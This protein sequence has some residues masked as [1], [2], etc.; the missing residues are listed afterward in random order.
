MKKTIMALL[1]V[2]LFFGATNYTASAENLTDYYTD[3]TEKDLKNS[4]ILSPDSKKAFINGEL[5][6]AVQPIIKDGRTLVPLRFIAEGFGAKVDYNAK[7]QMITI[8]YVNQ[9]ITLK[10]GNKALTVNGKT[11]QMDVVANIDNNTTYI[12][13]RAIGEALHK[14]VVYLD[15]TVLR[16]ARFM[17]IRDADGTALENTNLIRT[18]E[19]LYG[20]KSV[21]YSDRFMVMVKENGRLFSSDNFYDFEP[22]HY[23]EF[24]EDKNTVRLGDIWFKTAMG[25]FYLHYAHATTQEFIL[26][27]V[28]GE[29]LTRVAIEQAPIKAVK[30]YGNNVYYVTQYMRGIVNAHETSNL[31]VATLKDGQWVSDYLGKHGFYYVFDTEGNAHDWTISEQGI[32]TFGYQ[33]F[34]DSAEERKATFGHYRIDL[35][36]HSHELIQ[37]EN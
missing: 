1:I 21:V 16:N 31:K 29:K 32:K 10:I 17:V 37:H 30:T 12:P 18:C 34:G 7:N 25:N 33:R 8:K 28:D 26:Y 24:A 35:N 23:Q 36:G 22:F 3:V 15:Y 14:K 13:L 5:T 9:T 2:V 19:L 6:T 11:M 27:H 20:G 4:M